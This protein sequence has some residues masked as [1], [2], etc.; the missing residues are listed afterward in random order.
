MKTSFVPKPGETKELAQ[1]FS[2]LN[3]ASLDCT[4]SD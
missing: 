3:Y 1:L 4:D 2:L